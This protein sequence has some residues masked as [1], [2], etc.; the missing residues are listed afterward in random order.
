MKLEVASEKDMLGNTSFYLTVSYGSMD[1][2]L[3]LTHEELNRLMKECEYILH[4]YW[5][6]EYGL[7]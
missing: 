1:L 7:D 2:E 6:E 5:V 4:D 3:E